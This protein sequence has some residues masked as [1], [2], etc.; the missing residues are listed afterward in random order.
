M[1]LLVTGLLIFVAIHM[2]P[3]FAPAR[4]Q[5]VQKLGAGPYKGIFS[6]IALLGLVL[7]IMGKAG[8]PVISVWPPPPWGRHVALALMPVSCILLA[9]AYMPTNL[10]RLTPHPMLWGVTLWAAVH[11]LANGDL[12]S[13]VLFGGFGLFALC[14]MWSANLRG[15]TVS[16]TRHAAGKDALVIGVGLLVYLIL[17]FAHRYLFGVSPM[18]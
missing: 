3:T 5:L 13:T 8:A 4:R 12:A 18:T 9:A 16:T 15:A 11:L 1:L 14:A 6:V 17:L 10:K 7:V 2:L